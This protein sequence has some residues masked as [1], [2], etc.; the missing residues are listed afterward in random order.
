MMLQ[1]VPKRKLS[2]RYTMRPTG[3]TNK[4]RKRGS[5]AMSERERLA[6]LAFQRAGE[7]RDNGAPP[8]LEI[9]AVALFDGV[10]TLEV[11]CLKCADWLN[12]GPRAVQSTT[13]SA[14]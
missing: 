10:P 8:D 9:G 2:T 6:N 7:L 1:G 11:Y 12:R 13:L 3:W 5:C 4:M 14:L